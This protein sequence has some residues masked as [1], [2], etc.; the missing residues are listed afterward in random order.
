MFNAFKAKQIDFLNQQPFCATPYRNNHMNNHNIFVQHNI[1]KAK[2]TEH[3][4]KGALF[5]YCGH[6]RE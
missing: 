4:D 3:P 1:E 6:L 2:C 5:L